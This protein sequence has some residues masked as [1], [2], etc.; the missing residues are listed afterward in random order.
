M[1]FVMPDESCHR[2]IQER[3]AEFHRLN[4]WV[5]EKL[6]GL[7]RQMTKHRQHIGIGMLFEVLR[8]NY[9]QSTTDP[10]AKWKLNNVYRSRYARLIA[11]TEPDLR[12]V[13]EQREL[14]AA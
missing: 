9:Y 8:W 4:P 7:A 2:T 1:P 6:V 10:N 13:F 3:F 11:G 14:K 12:D 5:Y